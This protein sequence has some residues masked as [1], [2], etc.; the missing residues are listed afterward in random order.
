MAQFKQAR[1]QGA[2]E[3]L[4]GTVAGQGT[5][6]VEFDDIDLVKSAFAGFVADPKKVYDGDLEKTTGILATGMTTFFNVKKF[7]DFQ[8]VKAPV[9]TI[10]AFVGA[11]Y[12]LTYVTGVIEPKVGV[13]AG[14]D[15][16][17]IAP[18]LFPGI[19][20]RSV[21]LGGVGPFPSPIRQHTIITCGCGGGS[22]GGGGGGGGSP[23][24]PSIVQAQQEVVLAEVNEAL[25]NATFAGF[26]PATVS[27]VLDKDRTTTIV[28][29]AG[30]GSFSII[31][32]Q[33]L[34]LGRIV[35]LGSVTGLTVTLVRP[36]LTTF[37]PI[38]AVTNA[39][40]VDSGNFTPTE[41]VRIDV[42]VTG[43]T[44]IGEVQAR[45][46]IE[47]KGEISLDMS[48]FP[49]EPIFTQ[50]RQQVT[51]EEATVGL[52]NFS[53]PGTAVLD[54][55]TSTEVEVIDDTTVASILVDHTAGALLVS[56]VAV[57]TG[58]SGFLATD[59]TIEVKKVDGS[60]VTVF[61]RTGAG[62][63]AGGVDT[64]NFAPILAAS[65]LV[66]FGVAGSTYDVSEI[67]IFKVHEVKPTNGPA[68]PVFAQLQQ[69]ITM[70]DIL[71]FTPGGDFV[72]ADLRLLF[73]KDKSTCI[74]FDGTVPG[75]EFKVELNHPKLV[76]RIAVIGDFSGAN[77]I[78]TVN[79]VDGLND[80]EVINGK[81]QPGFDSGNFDPIMA[82]SVTV[83]V[84]AA[85]GTICELAIFKAIEVKL[86]PGSIPSAPLFVQDRGQVTAREVA[87][88]GLGANLTPVA[89]LTPFDLFDQSLVAAVVVIAPGAGA[90][91][92]VS[93]KAPT[94]IAEVAVSPPA[95]GTLPTTVAITVTAVGGAVTTVFS[96]AGALVTPGG[97]DSGN[98]QPILAETITVTFGIPGSAYFLAEVT[99]LKAHEVKSASNLNPLV[100]SPYF[101]SGAAFVGGNTRY[102]NGDAF[103]TPDAIG[104]VAA[105]F[106]EVGKDQQPT[107]TAQS[108]IVAGGGVT[109]YSIFLDWYFSF[110]GVTWF[111]GGSSVISD[112]AAAGN[113]TG[114][115]AAA[116]TSERAVAKPVNIYGRF[117]A[118]VARHLSGAGLNSVTLTAVLNRQR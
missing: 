9:A 39:N 17:F 10:A 32:K 99:I 12:S 31:F 41:V 24:A 102:A 48:N 92:T 96:R 20:V 59:M 64:G 116:G 94:L 103:T 69:Q 61:E 80:R 56:R 44:T 107:I 65:V 22:G 19:P 26:A 84:D 27:T 57:Q 34:L 5:G 25:S 8:I 15:E 83:Q 73:D 93:L 21:T 4:I 54:K 66:S 40:G 23:A 109:T 3:R 47:T 38:A 1:Q 79:S 85:A 68:E 112:T 115:L 42:A 117:I 46:V 60:S 87:A 13:Y 55:D 28:H 6:R 35:V 67:L 74:P 97:I 62:V 114:F 86:S 101:V 36:N 104:A 77:I 29:G 33:S 98:F 118:L 37:V 58:D 106:V 71:G 50:D 53:P 14:L 7:L 72:D 63:T 51:N 30:A 105:R 18:P 43:A 52:V 110:D 78:V 45:K 108:R 111:Y 89:P 100:A 82:T 49:G 91:L 16:V 81:A 90:V 2:V 70:G 88:I 76:S 11:G 75:T 95:A 113:P